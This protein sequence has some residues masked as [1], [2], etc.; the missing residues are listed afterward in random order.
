MMDFRVDYTTSRGNGGYIVVTAASKIQ[1][2]AKAR[3]Q[4][5]LNAGETIKLMTVGTGSYYS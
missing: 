2:R 5:I 4:I 1:A 3:D